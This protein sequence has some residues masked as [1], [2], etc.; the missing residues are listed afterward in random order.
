T[1][2]YLQAYRSDLSA[3][4]SSPAFTVCKRVLNKCQ[5]LV[6]NGKQ[7]ENDKVTTVLGTR[8]M[9]PRQ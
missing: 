3:N 4:P 6:F 8:E 7:D 9:F 5:A 1:L 2:W